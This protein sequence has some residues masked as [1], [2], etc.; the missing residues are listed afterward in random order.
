VLEALGAEREEGEG[1]LEMEGEAVV[2]YF[3]VE[4][5]ALEAALPIVVIGGRLGRGHVRAVVRESRRVCSCSVSFVR[6]R[7]DC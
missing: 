2:G 3:R 4:R 5:A 1:R 6:F 7:V